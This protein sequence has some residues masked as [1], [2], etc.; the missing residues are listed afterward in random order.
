MPSFPGPG[1]RAAA[2]AVVLLAV[3]ASIHILLPAVPAAGRGLS[4]MLLFG[5]LLAP[6]VAWASLRRH[7]MAA[8]AQRE[9]QERE[10]DLARLRAQLAAERTRIAEVRGLLAMCSW[11]K[12]IRDG[13]GE[14]RT[15][16]AYLE[17]H[18]QTVFSHG[19]CD[20]CMRVQYPNL[21]EKL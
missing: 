21:F 12:G 11:C 19:V 4:G 9:L 2:E 15:L 20:E 3:A 10:A 17:H 7:R 5:A 14:W 13:G 1:S 6:V 8:A 18:L 16:E